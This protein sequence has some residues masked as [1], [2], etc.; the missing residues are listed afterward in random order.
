MRFL[1]FLLVV[2][3]TTFSAAATSLTFRVDMRGRA[4][5]PAGVH[6]AGNFQAAAG[7]GGDWNPATT[8]LTDADA[9]SVFELTVQVP[10]G[11][12]AYKYVNGTTWPE[13][14]IVPGL[15]GYA[16]GG[17][18]VN[19]QVGVANGG[20]QVLPAYRFGECVA[21]GGYAAGGATAPAWWHDAVFYEVFVRSFYDQ[22][23]DGRGDFDGLTAKLDY[24]NDGDPA[25][26]TDLGVTAL[27]LMPM[28]ESPSYHGYDVTNYKATEPDYGSMVQ[29]ETFL[30]AAHQRGIK[31]II[32]LVLNHS[33]NQHPW[34]VGS[35]S[36]T[37]HPYRDWYR[38]SATNPG[39]P[40]PWGQT[41]W[42]PR[43]GQFYYGVFYDGMPDLN[44][45][46]PGLRAAMWSATRFWLNKGV[47]GY[48][49]DAVKYLD[50]DGAVTENTPGTLNLLAELRDSVRA[51]NPS[52]FLVGEA[53][54]ATNAVQPYVA[55]E[56]LDACFEFDVS[57][58]IL[59]TLNSTNPEPL[60]VQLAEAAATY[61]FGTMATFLTNH[62]QNRV[63]DQLGQSM[64]KMKQAADL[65][66]T[67][68]GVPFLYYGEEV[69]MSGT[70]PDPDKRRPMQWTAGPRAGFTTGNPW[71]GLNPN[72]A[73][74]NVAT[75]AADPASLLNH[76][77]R[78]IGVRNGSVA[79]RQGYYLPLT[80]GTLSV[81]PAAPKLVAFGR[82]VGQELV[83]VVANVGTTAVAAPTVALATSELAAGDYAVTNLLTGQ[84]AGTVSVD[85]VGGFGAWHPG[86]LGAL[87]ANQTWVLR[88]VPQ[89]VGLAE[90]ARP[91]GPSLALYPNPAVGRVR[92]MLAG[93]GESAT[94]TARVY[95]LTGRLLLTQPLAG[96]ASELDVTGLAAGA[97]VVRVAGEGVS[98]ARRL[99][100]G[101]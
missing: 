70:G 26:T 55:E 78:L 98:V 11:T 88:L 7:F 62:D 94:A 100:V 24:L 19:R 5:S 28:M 15:C 80:P 30:A 8:A 40:G 23:G 86:A 44:W 61:P 49:L 18:N 33:S 29:F 16:D 89:S 69:G 39:Q 101:R 79:L 64:P 87:A 12:Y 73:T 2:L 10:A 82:A 59:T 90:G 92:L 99:V 34:F 85:S 53:W 63:F 43:G 1:P 36:S 45:D 4:I 41:V 47:D 22:S 67:L 20:V 81:P 6:V 32:D 57:S 83:L 9:D 17:G 48:R 37:A 75:M 84:A 14:E 51:V 46:S 76:Y 3:L 58:A 96:A 68:P 91:G 52:A 25:T 35:A 95:D 93:V 21:R 97:Y 71:S 50:E 72:Y 66:L 38:W 65:L 56:R 42:H 27:W 54:S 60:R 31:V 74:Y 13:S 77:R